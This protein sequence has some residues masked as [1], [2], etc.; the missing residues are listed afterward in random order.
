MS[1]VQ[2]VIQGKTA[3]TIAFVWMQGE[4]TPGELSAVYAERP[5]RS[6]QTAP[7]RLK[8]PDMAVVIG[9]L[10]DYRKG[11]TLGRRACGQEKVAATIRGL[12]GVDTDDLNGPK[13]GLHYTQEEYEELAGGSRPRR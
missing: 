3:D 12:P 6:H 11:D 8:R 9:R 5:Q 10:S 4:G 7:R 2:T 13:N 1:R